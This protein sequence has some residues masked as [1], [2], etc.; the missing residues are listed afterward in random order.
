[1]NPNP[2]ANPDSPVGRYRSLSVTRLE[3]QGAYLAE[4]ALEGG[5]V[6]L[7]ARFVPEGTAVGDR[8]DVFVYTHSED[9][10]V[11][12]TQ[13]PHAAVGDFAYLRVVDTS[14]HGAFLDWGLDK[15]LFAPRDEQIRDLEEGDK[16]V[17]AV[18][19]HAKTNRVIACS[20]LAPHFS[21]EV[22]G[23]RSG[24]LVD[25]LVYGKTEQGYRVVVNGRYA[26]M[27]YFSEAFVKLQL[28]QRTEGY[29]SQL[30]DDGRIDVRLQ[31]AGQAGVAD[32]ESVL[33]HAIDDAGGFLDLHDKSD[34]KEIRARLG[35]SK[36]VF[37]KAAG[38]LYRRRKIAI[39]DGGLRRV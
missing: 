24:D 2:P 18:Q 10:P 4:P 7:P 25:L 28:G 27:V 39:E 1:M 31:R 16:A 34:P 22:E 20:R 8:F 33:L 15:D 19:L 30:R 37:K 14:V 13:T 38:G 17:F 32:A 23:L 6:L 26:G 11:A 12:T 35:I 21:Y 36:K 29:V 3:K 5:E 9:R